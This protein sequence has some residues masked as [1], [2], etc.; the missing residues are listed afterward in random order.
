MADKIEPKE[1][2]NPVADRV[3]KRTKEISIKSEKIV[4]D[5]LDLLK[6]F[7]FKLLEVR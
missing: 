5:G 4:N 6:D 3:E 1:S 7:M 2:L